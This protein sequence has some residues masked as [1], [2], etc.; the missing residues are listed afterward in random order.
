[1]SEKPRY[2]RVDH[3]YERGLV[4]ELVLRSENNFGH[5]WYTLK[6]LMP[7]PEDD[8]V[9]RTYRHGDVTEV[10]KPR[11]KAARESNAGKLRGQPR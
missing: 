4:G 3:E 5:S 1:M 11:M 8:T 6:I 2:F 9:L 7:D 10:K